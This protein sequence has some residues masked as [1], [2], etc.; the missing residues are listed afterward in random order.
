MWCLSSLIVLGRQTPSECVC[1]DVWAGPKEPITNYVL[2]TLF[3]LGE[4]PS[5]VVIALS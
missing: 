5:A 3:C 1:R 2:V 4:G